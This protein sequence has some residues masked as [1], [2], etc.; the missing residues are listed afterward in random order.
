MYVCVCVCVCRPIYIISLQV[1]P[2]DTGPTYHAA[3]AKT[4]LLSKDNYVY[5]RAYVFF[6][7]VGHADIGLIPDCFILLVSVKRKFVIV[8]NYSQCDIGIQEVG[9]ELNAF[10]LCVR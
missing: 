6:S 3:K 5:V 1:S 9:V 7:T 4:L 2:A 8:L 10:F